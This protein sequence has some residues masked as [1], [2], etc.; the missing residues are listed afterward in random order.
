MKTAIKEKKAKA[1]GPK[2]IATSIKLNKEN[3]D[4]AKKFFKEYD[5]TLSD[6]INMFLSR[7][8]M[9]KRLPFEIEIP[10]AE[11][12][13]AMEEAERGEVTYSESVE[14]LIR[15]LRS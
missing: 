12:L 10:S 4:F 6:G 3:R 7:V 9:D 11:L 1:A 14:D 2:R 5:L 15:E 13:E 8:A